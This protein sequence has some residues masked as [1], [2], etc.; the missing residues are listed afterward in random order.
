ALVGIAAEVRYS[1]YPAGLGILLYGLVSY[2]RAF[3]TRWPWIGLCLAAL[4][5]LPNLLY[6][7]SH[8]FAA[9]R[10]QLYSVLYGV[11]PRPPLAA[12]AALASWFFRPPLWLFCLAYLLRPGPLRP[13]EGVL[14]LAGSLL[15]APVLAGRIAAARYLVDGA[16]A[17]VV[18]AASRL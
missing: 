10:F 11:L 6:E 15:L 9:V 1:A 7:A 4:F 3:S 16:F 17:L 5:V 14:I 12:A 18:L 13:G 8:G 2:R